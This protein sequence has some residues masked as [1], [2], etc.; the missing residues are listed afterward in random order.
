MINRFHQSDRS[1]LEQIL[2]LV[3]PPCKPF[4]NMV[5][6]SQIFFYQYFSG[7]RI[8]CLRLFDQY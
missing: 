8:S 1:G 6:Q 4:H 5:N 3:S 7:R 2:Y